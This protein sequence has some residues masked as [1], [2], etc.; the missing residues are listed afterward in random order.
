MEYSLDIVALKCIISESLNVEFI[1]EIKNFQKKNVKKYSLYILV[2]LFL[3]GNW[4]LPA[5]SLS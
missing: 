5:T 2:Y 4:M 1:L 3:A